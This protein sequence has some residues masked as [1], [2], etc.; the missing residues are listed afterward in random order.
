MGQQQPGATCLA[1]R[2][3]KS[4]TPP[5]AASIIMTHTAQPDLPWGLLLGRALY[6]AAWAQHRGPATNGWF[7]G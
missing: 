5:N 7:A 2:G 4:L 3:A 6:A 1:A